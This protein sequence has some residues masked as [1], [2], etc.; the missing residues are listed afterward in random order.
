MTRISWRTRVGIVLFSLLWLVPAIVQSAPMTRNSA[1]F[2]TGTNFGTV[3]PGYTSLPAARDASMTN[4]GPD[5]AIASVTLRD[6]VA[7]TLTNAY[8]GTL[9]AG[10]TVTA[11][12]LQPIVGLQPGVHQDMLLVTYD[13]GFILSATVS[14]TVDH[15]GISMTVS[16]E[17][18]G[19]AVAGY[20]QPDARAIAVVNQSAIA[21]QVVSVDLMYG[22]D[23]T[24]SSRLTGLVE[25]GQTATAA[26]VQPAAD[27]PVGV[28]S[29]MITVTYAGGL[30]A[31][32]A[33]DF[34]VVRGQGL[35]M[36]S[37]ADFNV[38][39]VGYAQAPDAQTLTLTNM[40]PQTAEIHSV[41]LA[42]G[43]AFTLTE[44][45][46]GEV[47]ANGE[48]AIAKV[49]PVVGLSADLHMDTLIVTYDEGYIAE[50]GIQFLVVP[51]EDTLSLTG[52]TFD[53]LPWGYAELPAAQPPVLTNNTV[54][55]VTVESV[56]LQSGECFTLTQPFTGD[57]SP[58]AWVRVG[59]IQPVAGLSAGEYRDT[60]IVRYNGT[61]LTADIILMVQPPEVYGLEHQEFTFQTPSSPLDA[62]EK[63]WVTGVTSS[64]NIR[65]GP[66]LDASIIGHVSP[67]EAL[68]LVEWKG[69]WC[70]VFYDGGDRIG[71]LY[72]EFIR[73]GE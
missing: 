26:L 24:L 32:G 19:Q 9:Q 67:N 31:T 69:D 30:T 23:F 22:I 16:S 65:S 27:L 64:A 36:V 58:G 50:A 3:Q 29:D 39:S 72:G 52:V 59:M 42:R 70:R 15:T 57:I 7:F 60:V 66:G 11:A 35:L 71:W 53:A 63:A 20:A 6:G 33:V 54:E 28:Y 4:H 14:F 21:L 38:A 44:V 61:T 37:G 25:P 47:A 62:Y 68:W 46:T 73:V 48:I 41:R 13:G 55:V 1:I 49:Q 51:G 56:S 5:A 10:A 8:S 12:T 2:L 43:N 18:F 40:A 34:A 45:F 17:D